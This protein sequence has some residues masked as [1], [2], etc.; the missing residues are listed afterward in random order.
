MWVGIGPLLSSFCPAAA[1][2]SVVQSALFSERRRELSAGVWCRTAFKPSFFTLR[3]LTSHTATC[4]TNVC[5][6]PTQTGKQGRKTWERLGSHAVEEYNLHP[7]QMINEKNY[8]TSD[9]P[10]G[11][12]TRVSNP[13][14]LIR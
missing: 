13:L 11:E 1:R 9:G 7:Y 2:I 4:P 12:K 14:D 3:E 5:Q 6:E 10:D 8:N